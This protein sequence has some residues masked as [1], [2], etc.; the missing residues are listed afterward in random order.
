M[1]NDPTISEV[2]GRRPWGKIPLTLI[3]FGL[4]GSYASSLFVPQEPLK[5]VPNITD[6]IP[7][8]IGLASL[9]IMLSEVL[10]S[11]YAVYTGSL[12]RLKRN[13]E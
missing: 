9:V 1:T 13:V 7:V 10:L 12:R 3:A 11:L 2:K 6:W 5:R 8:L 4:I